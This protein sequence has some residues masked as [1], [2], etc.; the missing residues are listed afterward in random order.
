MENQTSNQKIETNGQNGKLNTRGI[1][2]LVEKDPYFD[3]QFK[4]QTF[5]EK[6]MVQRFLAWKQNKYVAYMA[7]NSNFE[8]FQPNGQAMWIANPTLKNRFDELFP[9]HF[10]IIDRE[11]IDN[12]YLPRD[13]KQGKRYLHMVDKDLY[14]SK[15]TQSHKPRSI[16]TKEYPDVRVFRS[17]EALLEYLEEKLQGL[18]I[19]CIG[20]QSWSNLRYF[21]DQ[22]Q[23]TFS[24]DLPNFD[25]NETNKF[26]LD[27]F[28]S[29]LKFNTIKE[30]QHSIKTE[31]I[32]TD[33]V[34]E[35]LPQLFS[36]FI[37]FSYSQK[38]KKLSEKK[39]AGLLTIEENFQYVTIVK[40]KR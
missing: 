35:E 10:I 31:I 28:Q 2:Y 25:N 19:I 33:D 23:I 24:D 3:T 29:F 12:N 8:S 38:T 14:D 36:D 18:P 7:V 4:F 13:Y 9:W 22:I 17:Y 30:V 40:S 37:K 26:P 20:K 21:I 6:S 39:K 27:K 15:V 1:Q 11:F 16:Q 32:E 34:P 5:E